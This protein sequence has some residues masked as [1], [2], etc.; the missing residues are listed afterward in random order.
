MEKRQ[1]PFLCLFWFFSYYSAFIL[2]FVLF[3]VP[4][5]AKNKAVAIVPFERINDFILVDVYVNGSTP[6]Q[7][8]FDSGI[9]QTILSELFAEDS[10]VLNYTET[11][12]LR[13]LGEGTIV[14]AYLSRKN[15]VSLKG[16]HFP[17][18]NVLA[19]KEQYFMFSEIY[20]RKV[21]GFLGLDILQN[22]ILEIDYTAKKLKFYQPDN[23][24]V[25][26]SYH[27]LPVNI[28]NGRIFTQLYIQSTD[29]ERLNKNVLIDTGAQLNAWFMEQNLDSTLHGKTITGRIGEG[30][31]GE[32][33]GKYAKLTELIFGKY[34]FRHPVVVFP[35]SLTIGEIAQDP[36]RDGTLGSGMLIRFNL[37]LDLPHSKMYIK[38]NLNY[39]RSF[40]YNLAGIEIMQPF[41]NLPGYQ[42]LHVWEN[43]V[44]S[45]A[46]LLSGDN[47]LEIDHEKTA[48]MNL[49]EVQGYFLK[50]SPSLE[51]KISRNDS[52]FT[53]NLVLKDLLKTGFPLRN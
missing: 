5:Y 36:E 52:V 21:N 16:I 25:P 9:R 23:Y 17:D 6:L 3:Q 48:S 19:L 26:S 39:H 20:G 33:T 42:I 51:M 18:L 22:H 13:G 8:I 1:G 45:G 50:R 53:V 11:Q 32:I 43:S 10:V 4:V 2:L 29:G 14:E 28:V 38:P 35:S 47:I 31:G 41:L 30:F 44:A 27:E 15:D 7:L 34:F 49:D 37:I 12:K 40:R 46:G 24:T